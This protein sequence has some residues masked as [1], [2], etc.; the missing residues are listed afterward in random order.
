MAP[1]LPRHW[2]SDL[3][4]AIPNV[5]LRILPTSS[6]VSPTIPRW[7]YRSQG[8]VGTISLQAARAGAGSHSQGSP[9]GLSSGGSYRSAYRPGFFANVPESRSCSKLLRGLGNFDPHIPIG[10]AAHFGWGAGPRD[11]RRQRRDHPLPHDLPLYASKPMLHGGLATVV[12]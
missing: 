11:S 2:L 7:Q 1:R 4:P 3:K 8:K 5:P 6:A 10:C 9:I 12:A